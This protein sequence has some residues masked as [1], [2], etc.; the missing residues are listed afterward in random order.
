MQEEGGEQAQSE[1]TSSGAD[2]S[3]TVSQASTSTISAAVPSLRTRPVAP[4]SRQHLILPEDGGDDGKLLIIHALLLF[5]NLVGYSF[6]FEL[7]SGIRYHRS[8]VM[9]INTCYSTLSWN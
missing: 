2:N 4:L 3:V 7:L 5:Y 6:W 8:S 1:A 9:C